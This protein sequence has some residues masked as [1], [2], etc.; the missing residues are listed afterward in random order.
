[1]A[2]EIHSV[3]RL[4]L[5]AAREFSAR[6]CDKLRE[7]SHPDLKSGHALL[8]ANWDSSGTRISTLAERA[9]ITKQAM[10]V[11]VKEMESLGYLERT[12]DSLDA[13]AVLV[14]PTEKGQQLLAD[15]SRLMAEIEAEQVEKIGREA[16][17]QLQRT[18][19]R[20]LAE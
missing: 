10:G 8:V 18:L 3:G 1:M 7:N 12:K 6:V 2:N 5:T 17:E 4:L 16:L 9:E 20:M 13:R 15:V 11:L 14:V 19:Q